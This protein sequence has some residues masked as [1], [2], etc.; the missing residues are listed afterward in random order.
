MYVVS[1]GS[2]FSVPETLKRES[3]G[4]AF[5]RNVQ[6]QVLKEPSYVFGC[7]LFEP[8]QELNIS[9]GGHLS[10]TQALII[11]RLGGPF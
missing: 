2:I 3:A 8:F 9:A 7:S 1:T 6:F 4:R 5:S 10:D 11:R